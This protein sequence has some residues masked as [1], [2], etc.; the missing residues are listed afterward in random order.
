MDLEFLNLRQLRKELKRHGLSPSGLKADL[1]DRLKEV[2]SGSDIAA[3]ASLAR[4]STPSSS[5]ERSPSASSPRKSDSEEHN[6][7]TGN[8]FARHSQ[9]NM[10]HSQTGG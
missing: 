2:A 4:D 7:R 9:Q 10:Q 5:D 3:T 1:V 6:Q 8:G